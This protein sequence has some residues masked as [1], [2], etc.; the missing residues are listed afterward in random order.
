[1][2]RLGILVSVCSLA[3]LT[4]QTYADSSATLDISANE[5]HARGMADTE[6]HR[7]DLL[8]SKNTRNDTKC[9]WSNRTK[10]AARRGEEHVKEPFRFDNLSAASAVSNVPSSCDENTQRPKHGGDHEGHVPRANHQ[11]GPAADLSS[12]DI[13]LDPA[14]LMPARLARQVEK[15]G[16]KGRAKSAS[17]EGTSAGEVGASGGIDSSPLRDS[18]REDD[19]GVAEDRYRPQYP[20]WYQRQFPNQRYQAS[21]RRVPYRN[22]LRYPVFP[23]R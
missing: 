14:G 12:H 18:D 16:A 1:M 6:N 22:Y 11:Q 15:D 13:L 17:I 8:K 2:G 5:S 23:G 21:D 20:Y 19:L 3:L 4:V 10:D 9:L 7:A